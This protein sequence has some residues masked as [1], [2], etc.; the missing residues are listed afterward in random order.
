MRTARLSAGLSK[1][2]D[3]LVPYKCKRPPKSV[4]DHVPSEF[5]FKNWTAPVL[6]KFHDH[7]IGFL[8]NTTGEDID[9]DLDPIVNKPRH[10]HTPDHPQFGPPSVV[11]I[12]LPRYL[13]QRG[14]ADLAQ[15]QLPVSTE[16][17]NDSVV[18]DAIE[19]PIEV[20]L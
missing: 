18:S 6:P 8:D 19:S 4:T 7:I 2:G 20:E 17:M 11:S 5:S 10:T 15:T 16:C 3:I 12:G 1:D 14:D 9:I 13:Q